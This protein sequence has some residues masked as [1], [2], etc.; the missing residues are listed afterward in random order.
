MGAESAAGRTG[1]TS[2]LTPLV[3]LFQT[4]RTIQPA[5]G[6]SRRLG[7]SGILQRNG[8][9][10]YQRN[11]DVFRQNRSAIQ[12]TAQFYRATNPP[13]SRSAGVLTGIAIGSGSSGVMSFSPATLTSLMR[14]G[15][16]QYQ[17]IDR[18]SGNQPALLSSTAGILI[19][20]GART[21]RESQL[22]VQ[23]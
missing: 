6:A 7:N 3:S 20:V 5:G 17:L 10:T 21:I 22:F 11:N 14:E 16:R 4:S 15:I 19:R 13:V 8:I 9:E 12:N 23:F 1:N 2:I 18:P